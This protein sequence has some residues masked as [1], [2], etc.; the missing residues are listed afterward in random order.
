MSG[1]VSSQKPTTRESF[2]SRLMERFFKLPEKWKNN[3][4][5]LAK[6]LAEAKTQEEYIEIAKTMYE[7]FFP[8]E[9]GGLSPLVK[10]TN[11][12]WMR[13]RAAYIGRQIKFHRSKRS[14]TQSEL[15]MKSG[16]PQSHIS[17]LERGQYSPSNV[18]IKKIAKALR[19]KPTDLD[20]AEDHEEFE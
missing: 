15:A 4:E 13:G 1:T 5:Q 17:R 18:T 20:Y 3:V 12:E 10:K 2:A 16:L 8:E 7:I 9:L 14:M 11:G 19:V 6:D